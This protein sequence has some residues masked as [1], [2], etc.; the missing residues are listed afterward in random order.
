MTYP[1]YPSYPPNS[2]YN[3]WRS[4]EQAAANAEAA[5]Q[6]KPLHGLWTARYG[7]IFAVVISCVTLAALVLAFLGAGLTPRAAAT[8]RSGLPRVFDAALTDNGQWDNTDSCYFSSSGL[9]VSSSSG[10]AQ[11]TYKPSLNRDLTSQGFLLEVTLAPAAS[12]QGQQIADISAAGMVVEVTQQGT[13]SVC[14]AAQ[15]PC[16]QAAPSSSGSTDAWHT[17]A[18]VANTVAIQYSLNDARLTVF[19]NSQQVAALPL[20]Q[21]NGPIALGAGA[22]GEVLYTHAALYS[23]S[24]S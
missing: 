15:L 24:G 11:C 9:D 2:G 20:T 8:A 4:Y 16:T 23:A 18:Y 13:Y 14:A 5:P 3:P 7:F 17:D 1:T 12:V 19:V 6:A 21:L 10:T 22:G